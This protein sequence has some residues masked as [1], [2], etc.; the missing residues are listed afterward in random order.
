MR[1][2]G[3]VSGGVS[4][5]MDYVPVGAEAGSRLGKAQKPGVKI[6]SEGEFPPALA[7]SG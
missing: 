5:K 1:I 2:G 3:K 4:K 7:S 6:I